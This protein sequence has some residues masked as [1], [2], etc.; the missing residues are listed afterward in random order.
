M[1][2]DPKTFDGAD[3][4]DKMRSLDEI[5]R[6]SLNWTALYRDPVT[7]QLWKEWLPWPESHGDGPPRLERID[8]A[9]ALLEFDVVENDLDD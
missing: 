2:S 1:G 6:D 3:A 4:Y 9:R 5:A 8:R 7:R